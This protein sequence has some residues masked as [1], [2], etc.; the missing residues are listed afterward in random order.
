[1]KMKASAKI[2]GMFLGY[3]QVVLALISQG[4]WGT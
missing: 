4:K 2:V 1:M 3:V